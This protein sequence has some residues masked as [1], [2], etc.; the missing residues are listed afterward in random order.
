MPTPHDSLCS[1]GRTH[2]TLTR[3][4]RVLVNAV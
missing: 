1:E 4:V 2:K 3:L